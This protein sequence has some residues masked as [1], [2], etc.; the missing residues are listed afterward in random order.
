M[1]TYRN[2]CAL[3]RQILF[4]EYKIAHTCRRPVGVTHPPSSFHLCLKINALRT[5]FSS[6][7]TDPR[8]SS[9]L[10]TCSTT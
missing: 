9:T 2:H 10:S 6:A 1:A 3:W 8:A 5:F 4:I 7:R